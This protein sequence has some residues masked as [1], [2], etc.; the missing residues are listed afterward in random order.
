MRIALF[1]RL[2]GVVNG[3][4]P[5]VHDLGHELVGV[6]TTEGPPG[7]YG[8]VPL[9]AVIDA[10]P[11]GTDVLVASSTRRFAPLL[12]AL[13][14]DLA[15]C[16]GFPLRIPA[17]A[18]AVP[19][20]GILNG[21][22]APLPRYRGPNPIAWALRNGDPELGLTFHFMDAEFDTGP[23]L[24]RGAVSIHAAERATEILDAVVGLW[25]S[26]LP[27]ALGLVEAGE[28]GTVQ[29]DDG[30]SYAGFF[31][32]EFAT[33]DLTR[34]AEE[35][36]RQV[37]AW[38]LAAARDGS[39]G[40]VT[41]LKGERVYVLYARLDGTEGGIAVECGDGRP[42]WIVETTP[43]SASRPQKETR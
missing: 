43:A 16:G 5:V 39:R 21:H 14:P 22:P 30:A 29:S 36:H 31:E 20:L 10:R 6:V 13:E 40:P 41:E 42:L 9:S 23:I 2:P 18:I 8:E 37:R 32:P 27:E 3:I 19:P 26:L 17:D 12:A 35:V 15:L 38:F 33:L 1:T 24:L 4:A 7:R 25:R 11:H 28:R 34:P